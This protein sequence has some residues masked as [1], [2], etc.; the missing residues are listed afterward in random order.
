MRRLLTA[1]DEHLADPYLPRTLGTRLER[2]GF[3][4]RR[5]AVGV[6]LETTC[7]DD[8][9][10]GG[11]MKLIGAFVP[12]RQGV[13]AGEAEEWANDLR[14]LAGTGEYFFSLNHYLFLA[15]KPR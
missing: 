10:S 12:G 7:G 1:W 13:T 5:R 2:A 15:E 3:A 8:T 11:I 6:T 9:L 4:L 14:K